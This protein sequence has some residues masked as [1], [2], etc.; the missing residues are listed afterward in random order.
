M[1]LRNSKD[2]KV[3]ENPPKVRTHRKW[4]TENEVDNTI[5]NLNIKIF[6]DR[7]KQEEVD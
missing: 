1:M 3:R 4:N 7:L 5:S 2:E 6:S